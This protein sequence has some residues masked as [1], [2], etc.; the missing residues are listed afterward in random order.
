MA[1]GRD[2]KNLVVRSATFHFRGFIPVDLIPVV[3]KRERHRTLETTIYAEAI[4]R[5]DAERIRHREWIAETRRRHRLEYLVLDE[6]TD[7]QILDLTREVYRDQREA[8]ESRR[9]EYA[10][11]LQADPDFE[12]G[13]YEALL[14]KLRQGAVI[15]EDSLG[16]AEDFTA[17]ILARRMIDISRS[18]ASREKLKRRIVDALVQVQIDLINMIT[19]ETGKRSDP[20]LLDPETRLPREVKNDPDGRAGTTQHVKNTL[21]ALAGEFL[22]EIRLRRRDKGYQAVAA[23]MR[24]IVGFFGPDINVKRL[25]RRECNRFRSFVLELPSNYTKRYPKVGDVRLIPSLRKPEHDLMSYANV[26]KILR[27]LIQF[28]GWLEEVEVIERAPST[29]NFTLRDPIPEK[30]KR[31]PFTADQLHCIFGSAKMKAEAMAESIFYWSY[32]I[33]LYQGIR[34]NE[35]ARLDQED[36]IDVDGSSWITIKMPEEI[37]AGETPG[38][39]KTMARTL[40]MHW[41]LIKLGLPE[42]ARSRPREAKLFMEARRGPDG[43]FSGD[44][45]DQ[46]REFLDNLGIGKGGPTFHSLRHNFRDAMSDADI[47]QEV[48]AYLGGWSLPGVMNEVY[49]S[50]R[51][52]PTLKGELDKIGYDQLDEKI[53]NLHPA[54]SM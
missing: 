31:K 23:S 18:P 21:S 29:K 1:Y 41:V 34:L 42:F 17:D 40:P 10:R 51:M 32:V 38:G 53:L 33:G 52:R 27:H 30:E 45:S 43:Y 46:T 37:T 48:S 5:R 14:L 7:E 25:R 44:V 54:G 2:M 35:I 11:K 26:N 22:G 12:V 9:D 15:G 50:T 3:G 6:L 39:T 19:G 20:S 47:S 4:H 16:L 28:L 36:I 49:G 24:L 13:G 8:A